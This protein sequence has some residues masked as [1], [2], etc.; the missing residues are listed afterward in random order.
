LQKKA[1]G[2]Y[3]KNVIT[4]APSLNITREEVDLAMRLLDEILRRVTKN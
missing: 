1:R 2:G 3:Y 4:L